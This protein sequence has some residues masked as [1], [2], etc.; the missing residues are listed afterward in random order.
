MITKKKNKADGL[1]HP[2]HKFRALPGKPMSRSVRVRRKIRV[3]PTTLRSLLVW[4]R[5]SAKRSSYGNPCGQHGVQVAS[6]TANITTG[7]WP[8]KKDPGRRGKT[9]AIVLFSCQGVGAERMETF[10]QVLT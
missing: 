3:V 6:S 7:L 9:S 2:E 1:L 10:F 8:S 4:F 5:I